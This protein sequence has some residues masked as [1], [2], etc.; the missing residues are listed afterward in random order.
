[1]GTGCPGPDI[2]V[3]NGAD[4]PEE[5]FDEDGCRIMDEVVK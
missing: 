1:M 5:E 4:C 2:C 3:P